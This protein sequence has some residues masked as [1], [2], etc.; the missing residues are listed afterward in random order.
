MSL[1]RAGVD[2]VGATNVVSAG[3]PRLNRQ[4]TP[5]Y[6]ESVSK[7]IVDGSGR[8]MPAAVEAGGASRSLRGEGRAKG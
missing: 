2:W 6:N 3:M 1:F 8:A 7:K 5:Y 4:R